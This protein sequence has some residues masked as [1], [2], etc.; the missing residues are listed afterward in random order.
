M[1]KHQQDQIACARTK[2]QG[3]KK[4]GGNLGTE[5]LYHQLISLSHRISNASTGVLNP[6]YSLRPVGLI[7]AVV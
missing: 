3:D 4:K 2:K 6:L 5:L 7:G 1:Q